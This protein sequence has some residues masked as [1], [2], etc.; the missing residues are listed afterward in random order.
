MDE[1]AKRALFAVDLVKTLSDLEVAE[2]KAEAARTAFQGIAI[3]WR[4]LD[5]QGSPDAGELFEGM[6]RAVDAVVAAEAEL[7]TRKDALGDLAKRAG[8]FGD[9]P[10]SH[11]E[12]D[13]IACRLRR[14]FEKQRS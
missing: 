1:K 14:G 5:T 4:R 7:T 8:E 2:K 6:R 12:C 3:E 9:K 11:G 10:A 13:C